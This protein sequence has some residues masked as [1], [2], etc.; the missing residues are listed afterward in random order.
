MKSH[1][2]PIGW[3]YRK[4]LKNLRTSPIYYLFVR[5]RSV[6]GRKVQ[7]C[8]PAKSVHMVEKIVSGFKDGTLENAD[9]WI[10]FAGD[11]I[12]IRYFPVRNES[13]D[14]MGVLEVTQEIGWIQKIEGQKLLL[15]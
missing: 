8:H 5:T 7:K 11:K 9:F 14:Y 12:L 1:S 2:A 4:K 15:D 10:D 3:S 6:I 13:G